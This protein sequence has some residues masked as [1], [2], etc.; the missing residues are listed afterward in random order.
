MTKDASAWDTSGVRPRTWLERTRPFRTGQTALRP[1]GYRRDVD[2]QALV[3]LIEPGDLVA[4]PPDYGGVSMAAT[5]ALIAARRAPLRLL[6]VPTSGM[7]VDLLVGAGL[8]SEV[9]AAAV[10]LGELG[11]APRYAAAAVAG[12]V[13]VRDST[14]PAVHAALQAGEKGIPFICLRGLIGSDL[15]SARTDWRVID[16]PLEPG[17]PIVVLPAIRPDVALFHAPAADRHGN[18]WIGRRRELATMAH[19]S[20]RTFVT[21]EELVDG[22]L[23]DDEVTAAGTLPALYVSAVAEAPG[24]A[25]PIGLPG[26]YD[27]D[28]DELERYAEA[29]R[30]PDRFRE[31]VDGFLRDERW[32]VAPS[33]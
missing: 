9:E 10:M 27:P 4:V 32:T 3:S 31:Y 13:T 20:F 29:A 17:D 23:L 22:S 24:G 8:V 19:A 2:V 33:S 15:L 5:R 26:R 18:V 28:L 21:V 12:E 30:D 11:A 14:C 16:N 25:W 6:A 1:A 7:Q